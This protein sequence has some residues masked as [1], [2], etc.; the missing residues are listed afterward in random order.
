MRAGRRSTIW[1]SARCSSTA[2]APRSTRPSASAAAF[3]RSASAPAFRCRSTAA[4]KPPVRRRHLRAD[5]A[6]GAGA[7]RRARPEQ[8]RGRSRSWMPSG[9]PSRTTSFD[10]VVAQ[11]VVTTVPNPEATLDEFARVLKPGGEIVLVSRVG[12]EAGLAA[13]LRALVRAD[14][15]PARLADRIPM[16]SDMKLGPGD[17]GHGADRA[18]PD[19]AARPF[20]AHPIRQGCG[21]RRE[22][23]TLR[24]PRRRLKHPCRT[25]FARPK[26]LVIEV[27]QGAVTPGGADFAE[28]SHLLSKKRNRKGVESMDGFLQALKTQRWDDHRYYHHSR[29]NQALHLVSAAEL[30]HRLRADVQRPGRGSAAGLAGGDDQPANRPL[31]LRAQG[32][33]RGEPRHATN[34]RKRSRSATTCSARSC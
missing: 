22:R 4:D 28:L 1:C 12:A 33:R 11:Y 32:L 15:A 20:L 27:F 34:T 10:V 13:R 3:S 9:S 14:G 26:E 19:A 21:G 16:G 25:T 31:L 7:G 23:E 24:G 17:A 18:P 5:A 29:I 2:G 30:R 6:Q 8:R